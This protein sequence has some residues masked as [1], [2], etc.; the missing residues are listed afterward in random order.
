LNSSAKSS[1]EISVTDKMLKEFS[2]LMPMHGPRVAADMVL[3]RESTSQFS[4]LY[5]KER[6]I[7]YYIEGPAWR[8]DNYLLE[9]SWLKGYEAA[10]QLAYQSNFTLKFFIDQHC[11]SKL[12]VPIH[13][14]EPE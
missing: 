9:R 13:T 12:S 4:D 1:T 8:H 14:D 6:A 2:H 3:K 11:V 10:C 7:N 5:M